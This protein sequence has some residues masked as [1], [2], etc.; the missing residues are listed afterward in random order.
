M[1]TIHHL[2]LIISDQRRNYGRDTALELRVH[3]VHAWAGEGQRLSHARSAGPGVRLCD[4]HE[5]R[6][7]AFAI[8]KLAFV[9]LAALLPGGVNAQFSY[10]VNN[11]AVTITAYNGPAGAVDVPSTIIGLPVVSIQHWAFDPYYTGNSANV[12]SVAIPDSVTNIDFEAFEYCNTLTNVSFGAGVIGIGSGAFTFCDGL[13]AIN[14]DTNN[15]AFTTVDGILFNKNQTTLIQCPPHNIAGDYI[16]PDTV[17]NIEAQAFRKCGGMTQVTIGNN[18]KDIG[19]GAFFYAGL[20]SVVIP[21]AVTDLSE[22]AFSYCSALTNATIGKGVTSIGSSTF[23]PCTGL[24]NVSIPTNVTSIGDQAFAGCANLP[25]IAI[26]DSV[27]NIGNGAFANCPRLGS[28]T[29]P[30]TVISIGGG[31]FYWCS[32]L[33]NVMIGNGIAIIEAN[34]FADCSRLTSVIIPQSVKLIGDSPFLACSALTAITVDSDNL[35]Y[36]SVDGVLFD[37]NQTALIQWPGGRGGSYTLPNSVTNIGA[38]AFESCV[39]LTNVTMGAGV[40]A[41]G[42]SAFAGCTNLTAVYFDGNAP[43]AALGVFG[44]ESATD[45]KAIAYYLP[46]T[47][48]WSATF[49]GIPTALWFL[50]NPM[51]LAFEP[52]FGVRTNN[53]G[54]TISWATNVPVVVEACTNLVSAVWSPVATNTL[55]SGTSYFSDPVWTNYPDRFYRLR[56][57]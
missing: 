47:T 35:G 52:N 22:G 40:T 31:T 23:S 26:P 21:N 29:I 56:S 41:I 45:S 50:P 55:T 8:A 54:F 34:A 14:A 17:T 28:I 3:P 5:P 27:T 48:G 42:N 51:I 38:G 33:T 49:D 57:P 37:K 15:P 24:I 13:I 30:G 20:T 19:Y 1:K 44:S 12:T 10:T 25:G 39:I 53:F 9:L 11:N 6:M 32:G 2:L 18:V 4:L 16:I 46:G 43:T 36:S 7:R